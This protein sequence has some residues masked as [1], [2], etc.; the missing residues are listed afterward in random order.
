MAF[1]GPVCNRWRFGYSSAYRWSLR[2]TL[3]RIEKPWSHMESTLTA[4]SP[5][6]PYI[7]LEMESPM[8][9]V[10]HVSTIA[11]GAAFRTQ[12]HRPGHQKR[13]I[14]SCKDRCLRRPVDVFTRPYWADG[15]EEEEFASL[16][17]V[18]LGRH[19]K[20]ITIFHLLPLNTR[21]YS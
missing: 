5:P 7:V 4:I 6:S 15:K 11:A 16:S 18:N 1:Q 21:L 13:W 3:S 2:R 8:L 20:S 17:R 9:L 14:I 12:E 19:R 10:L